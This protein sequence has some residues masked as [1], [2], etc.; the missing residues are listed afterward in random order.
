MSNNDNCGGGGVL[1]AFIFGALIGA[2]VSALLTPTTGRQNRERLAELRDEILDK[3]DDM[4]QTVRD[5]ADEAKEEL[6]KAS[7]KVQDTVKR[8]K[9]YME[10]KK[11]ILSSAIEAGKEAYSRQRDSSSASETAEDEVS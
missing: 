1:F 3:T 6:G 11:D 8:G 5:K 9:D 2:G 10:S 4:E 7:E